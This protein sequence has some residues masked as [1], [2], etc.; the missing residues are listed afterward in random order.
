MIR[1]Q[2]VWTAD[3]FVRDDTYR[4]ALARIV[5]AHPALPISAVWGNGATSSSDG[6][7]FHSGKRA[8]AGEVNARYGVDPGF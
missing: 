3:A 5:D 4:A 8:G 6:Q 1:D 2:L 7:F